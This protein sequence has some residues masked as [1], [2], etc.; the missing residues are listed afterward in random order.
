LPTV[1]T[2]KSSCFGEQGYE[3]TKLARWHR[4]SK[5]HDFD[6]MKDLNLDATRRNLAELDKLFPPLDDL[7]KLVLATYPSDEE[8]RGSRHTTPARSLR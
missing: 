3:G 8:A 6:S 7:F 5:A 1:S 2:A 4:K